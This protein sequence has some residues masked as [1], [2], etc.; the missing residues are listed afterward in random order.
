MWMEMQIYSSVNGKSQ[1]G[2]IWD[3][4]IMTTKKGQSHK[5]ISWDLKNLCIL[6]ENSAERLR[7]SRDCCWGYISIFE[8]TPQKMPHLSLKS[9]C[10]FTYWFKEGRN[11]RI[12]VTQLRSMLRLHAN[13]SSPGVYWRQK[14]NWPAHLELCQRNP[15]ILERVLN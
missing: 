14:P 3:K 12:A 11:W 4:D 6:P 1:V 8:N 5:K 9:C 10:N 7:P 15:G 2:N 13:T